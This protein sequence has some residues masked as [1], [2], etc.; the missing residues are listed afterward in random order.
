MVP[1]HK[2]PPHV[3]L[4]KEI[5]AVLPEAVERVRGQAGADLQELVSEDE[6]GHTSRVKHGGAGRD[7]C[8]SDTKR[9]LCHRHPVKRFFHL[10]R[11]R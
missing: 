4:V 8:H 2:P 11:R 6:R 1:E 9:V 5:V 7:S 10:L 3:H